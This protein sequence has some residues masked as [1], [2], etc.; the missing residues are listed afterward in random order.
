MRNGLG[1]ITGWA[2]VVA[3]VGGAV[4]G[5]LLWLGCPPILAAG[6]VAVLCGAAVMAWITEAMYRKSFPNLFRKF[7]PNR[8]DRSI[9][10][11]NS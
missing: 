2:A 4:F 3:I 10:D 5:V 11:R 6:M 8:R 1:N 7:E 9:G